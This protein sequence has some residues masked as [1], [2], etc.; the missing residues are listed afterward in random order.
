MLKALS[1]IENFCISH[2]FSPELHRWENK[3]DSQGTE[4]KG[5]ELKR[6]YNEEFSTVFTH[7]YFELA[8]VVI[9]TGSIILLYRRQGIA[10][11]TSWVE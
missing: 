1:Y 5:I 3:K 2:D 7:Y 11:G 6:E 4:R 9:N 10:A 8:H